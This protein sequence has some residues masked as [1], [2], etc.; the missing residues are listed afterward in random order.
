MIRDYFHETLTAGR[1]LPEGWSAGH[2]TIRLIHPDGKA[3]VEAWRRGCFAVHQGGDRGHAIITHATTGCGIWTAR[4][5]NEAAKIVDRILPLADWEAIDEP[6][7]KRPELRDKI[8][9]IINEIE[10]EAR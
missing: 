9:S 10:N 3:A 1:E 6:S 4:T 7:S 5:M 2:V 8:R